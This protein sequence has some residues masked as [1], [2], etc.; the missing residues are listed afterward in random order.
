[1]M[2]LLVVRII[3]SGALAISARAAPFYLRYDADETFPEQSGFTRRTIDPDGVLR[4]NVEDGV[5]TIDSR[6]SASIVDLYRVRS[7]AFILGVDEEFRLSWRMRTL[8]DTGRPSQTDVA[9]FITN[10]EAAWV[11]LQLGPEFVSED[12]ILFGE[13]E[14]FYPFAPGIFHEFSLRSTDMLSYGLFV[15][16]QFA[17]EG[18]FHNQAISGPN[19]VS[20]G[21]EIAGLASLSQWDYVEIAVVPEPELSL[22]L[23]AFCAFIQL[24]LH[25]SNP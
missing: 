22:W 9:M 20:F 7:D 13:P 18:R 15:D 23:L 4:R 3:L 16:G 6:A 8:E 14:H 24:S 12:E 2:R 1:M 19:L 11:D 25:R 5:F 10:N 21:D 17:F